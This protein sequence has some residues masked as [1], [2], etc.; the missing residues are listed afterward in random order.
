MQIDGKV[1]LVTSA[2]Q[3]IALG[4]AQTPKYVAAFVP[5]LAGPGSGYMTGQVPLLHGGLVHR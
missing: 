2:G 4:R 3:G 1:V 5:F